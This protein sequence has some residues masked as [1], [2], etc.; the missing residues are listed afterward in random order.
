M[1]R[2]PIK[3]MEAVKRYCEKKKNCK[4]CPI[5]SL[6]EYGY[7]LCFSSPEHWEIEKE[8]EKEGEDK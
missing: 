8:I 2:P 4:G 5:H 7:C 6:D 3:A 1:S